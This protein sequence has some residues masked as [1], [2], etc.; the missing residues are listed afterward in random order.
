MERYKPLVKDVSIYKEIA[1][2]IVNPLEILREAISNCHDAEAKNISILVYRNKSSNFTI[3]IQDDGKGMKID[4]IHRFFNL[5]DS[6]KTTVG[7]GEK[8]L[9][10]KI[11]FKSKKITLCT[12]TKD[13]EAYKVVMKS[14]WESLCDSVLPEYIVERNE[15]KLGNVGTS[16][17]IEDYVIDNP[18]K[19]FNFETIKDY[20]LWFT[21]AGSFKTY[22]ANYT[23][24]HKYI[25]NMQI[26]PRIFIEDRILDLKEEIAG[27]HQF[28]QPQENPKEDCG[29]TIYK[30]SI[31]YCRHF[32]PYHRATNIDGSYVS[33]QIYGT[34]SGVNCRKNI[35]KLRQGETLK[36]RFG[37]YLSKD[38]IP[39]TKKV[40]LITDPNFHHY[41]LLINSQAFE[42]TAD[43]NNISNADDAKV[44]WV[45][46]E[47]KKIINENIIPL[48][49]D[50]YFRIRRSEETEYIIKEKH[51]KI[52][53]RLESFNTIDNLG[54]SE[55]PI[56]KKPD[57][58]SQVTLLFAT[59][60]SNEKTKHLIKYISK[61]G[62]YSH[63]ATTDM[64]C[65]DYDNNKILVEVEY[66]LSNIFKH[67]HPYKTFDYV[68][69]WSVDLEINEKKKISDGNVLCLTKENDEWLLKYGTQKII[70]IIEL[71]KIINNLK[72]VNK[73]I[74]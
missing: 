32:G 50:G 42:L 8:G 62:H 4:D 21:A 57:N 51:R 45:F 24:L 40:N 58:E 64:I 59:I 55:L 71:G 29:E 60:M 43:R 49:S 74:I 26:A 1:Q 12:Q 14:P 2:N 3:E 70:P 65:L 72:S 61:I 44:K 7:I 68:V 30:R 73:E 22:F 15:V 63:Q 19:Y 69:C 66:K 25:N 39:F 38:F 41:H 23:E 67:D 47:A 34:I 53:E 17:M 31:N 18:E 11:Y 36:S 46:D 6:N 33:F 54:I 35:A 20:I 27:V 56:I 37:I 16:I 52:L 5:G 28:S 9:G 10:T 13:N 48:A